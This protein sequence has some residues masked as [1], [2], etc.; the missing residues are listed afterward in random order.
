M[1]DITKRD[2]LL[3]RLSAAFKARDAAQKAINLVF[4]ELRVIE[5]QENI[6]CGVEATDCRTI[7]NIVGD[8]Y[9]KFPGWETH[10]GRQTS[11]VWPRQVAQY[12]TRNFTTL[13]LNSIAKFFGDCDHG[14]ILHNVRQTGAMIQTDPDRRKEAESITDRI[15]AAMTKSQ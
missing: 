11:N 1:N 4:A 15:K 13:S 5:G 2:E 12:M 6:L 7:I 14:T 10:R 8:F 3:A 9:S